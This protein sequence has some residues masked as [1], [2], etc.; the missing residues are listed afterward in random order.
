MNTILASK[1]NHYSISLEL[2]DA[3]KAWM[4]EQINPGG[5]LEHLIAEDR[6]RQLY[7]EQEEPLAS[8]NIL[9]KRMAGDYEIIQAFH[10]G[11]REIVLGENQNA[12]AEERYLCAYCD[13]NEIFALYNDVMVSD[14]F[15]EI[16]KLYA[17]R[18]AEQAEKTRVALITPKIQGISNEPLTAGDCNP[19]SHDDDLN[20]KIVVIKAEVLRREYRRA[21]NQI[22][23]C[24]GGFGASPHSRGSACFCVDLYSGKTS[25]YERSDVL[26]TLEAEQLPKWAEHGLM[27]YQQ[28][29][30]QRKTNTK[31]ER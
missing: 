12:G 6:D 14:D 13:Q 29:Q 17:D 4:D 8:P 1:E 30:K 23:L 5:Y 2:D 19:V 9:K 31:E 15:C 10:I 25:R 24:I 3:L 28:E 22:K 7:P 11:D 26:G 21:T 18:L 20:N 27:S 16:T